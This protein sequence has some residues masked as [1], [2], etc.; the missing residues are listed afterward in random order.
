M[1]QAFFCLR[2]RMGGKKGHWVIEWS[3]SRRRSALWLVRVWIRRAASSFGTACSVIFDHAGRRVEWSEIHL[4]HGEPFDRY[5]K[6]G[7]GT[8]REGQEGK[9]GNLP[10][11]RSMLHVLNRQYVVDWSLWW[12]VKLD[13]HGCDRVV[14]LQYESYSS[15][16]RQWVQ[17]NGSKTIHMLEQ[18]E[19]F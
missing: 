6:E 17:I 2:E 13:P 4:Q 9:A 5:W 11:K 14:V 1:E 15:V 12:W 18:K 8:E 3:D 10:M 16:C 7:M 19:R